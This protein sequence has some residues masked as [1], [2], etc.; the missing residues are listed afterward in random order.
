MRNLIV[1]IGVI[2]AITNSVYSCKCVAPK[3]GDEVCGSDGK[4]YDSKCVL[5]CSGLYKKETEPCVTKVSN[6]PCGSTPC[7]CT[8]VCKHVCG[9]D[10]EDYG[11]DC[12]LECAQKLNPNLT[13]AKDGRC[14]Q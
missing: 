5:F 11:N 8:D 10:G 2:V 1:I 9:S 14:N 13:K 6:G 7:I 3:P 12:T 4:T